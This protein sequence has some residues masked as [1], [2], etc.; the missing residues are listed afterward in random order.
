MFLG[1]G[2]EDRVRGGR[3]RGSFGDV[4]STEKVES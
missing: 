1:M 4:V 3:V 2:G